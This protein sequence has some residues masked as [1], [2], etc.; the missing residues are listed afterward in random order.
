MPY[1]PLREGR[2]LSGVPF[3]RRISTGRLLALCAAVLAVAVGGTALAIAASS[4]G[5]VPKRKPLANAVHAAL[6]APEVSGVTARIRFTNHLFS[7]DDLNGSNPVI[8]GATGRLWA[9]NDG[10]FRL[11]LQSN[12]G[13]AQVV[14]NGKSWWAYD[15]QSHTVYR[16][17]VPQ[18][19]RRSHARERRWHTPSIT[20]IQRVLNRV[21]KKAA[22]TGPTPSNI[23]GQP[24]YTVRME[25][26]RNGGLL[27][28]LEFAWDAARGTPLRGAVYAR[29][30]ADPVLELAATDI[31]FGKVDASVFDIPAPKA[32]KVQRVKAQQHDGA[33][34]SGKRARKP[35]TGLARVRARTGFPLSAPATL[36]GRKRSHVALIG[37]DARHRGALVTYG[38]GLGGIAVVEH[39][40]AAGAKHDPL[41]SS[42]LPTVS[43]G[44]ASAK[45]LSTPLGTV[46][47]F[48]RAGVSYTVLAS[49]PR[50]AVEAAARGL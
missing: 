46:L 18:D 44:S 34:R 30:E 4:G 35:I 45:E 8:S 38:R 2:T 27:G 29:G 40:V 23:A 49:A 22:V 19:E 13:D 47:R 28:G 14:S 5:P 26:R 7:S 32:G 11:E 25:P 41:D 1:S 20:R 42:K 21:M 48:E 33:E 39:R 15:G 37:R 10:R 12:G 16:G 6:A 36:G 31:Q 24:A 50:A 17:A 3:L 43:I 9:T